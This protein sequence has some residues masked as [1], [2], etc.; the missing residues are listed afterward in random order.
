MKMANKFGGNKSAKAIWLISATAVILLIVVLGTLKNVFH[1]F[2]KSKNID[3]I[4]IVT[5]PIFE[6]GNEDNAKINDLPVQIFA[7]NNF[8]DYTLRF[9]VPKDT[10]IMINA[11]GEAADYST[12][13]FLFNSF[14][15][16]GVELFFD[17]KNDKAPLF[18]INGA[19]RQYRILWKTNQIDGKNF[20]K[21]GV[22]VAEQDPSLTTYVMEI[23][24][25]WK[26]LGFI[27]PRVNVKVGFDAAIMDNDGGGMKGKLNWRNTTDDDWN[28]TSH[29]GTMILSSDNNIPANLYYA[30]VPKHQSASSKIT[31]VAFFSRKSPFYKLKNV[32]VGYVKDSLD[33][34][35]KFRAEWD[36][37]NLYI[38]I[39]VRDNVKTFSKAL[40]DYGWKEDNHGDTVW[41]M[42]IDKLKFAGG[43]LKNKRV[44]TT[45]TLK[46]GIYYLKYH[47]DESHSPSKW[48]ADPPSTKFYGIKLSYSKRSPI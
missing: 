38:Q 25:P 33:L 32:S 12:N 42:D 24:L 14:D 9:N 1:L 35:G 28:N 10:S 31:S 43:A 16:D 20:N 26:S 8:K 23:S 21:T 41:R 27:T 30:V 7:K 29:Y 2:S 40:F 18:D 6:N 5:N 37:K 47:T 44:D 15:N 3:Y 17:M 13:P 4:S 11:V 36:D 46:K 48:D 22:K 45:I 39:F 19:D 34:S